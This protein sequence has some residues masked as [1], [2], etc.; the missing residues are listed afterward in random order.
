MTTTA[1]RAAVIRHDDLMHVS[2]AIA[3]RSLGTPPSP[4]DGARVGAMRRIAAA[5]LR[6]CGLDALRDDVCLIVSELLT[7]AILHSGAVT[8]SLVMAVRDGALYLSVEDGMRGS[9]PAP[10]R[11]DLDAESGRGLALVGSV[12]QENG[13]SW[14]AEAG[15]V[16]CRLALPVGESR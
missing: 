11:Y 12:V 14:G 10:S 2:F 1:V 6:Y 5:R 16:W 15:A 13:G 3:H 8:V 7:N 4:R 9:V